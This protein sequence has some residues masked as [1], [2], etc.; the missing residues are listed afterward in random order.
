MDDDFGF[1]EGTSISVLRQ[2]LESVP[3]LGVIGGAEYD[4]NLTKK[5][6]KRKIGL[7]QGF[8]TRR[9]GTIYKAKVHPSN[10][11]YTS[12]GDYRFAV[13]GHT[14]NFL[15]IRRSVLE[16]VAW[17]E[18]LW[19]AGEHLD[20]SL[21]LAQAGWLIGFTPDCWHEHRDDRIPA[22]VYAKRDVQKNL[23]EQIFCR[24][25]GI[26]SVE[27]FEF[28]SLLGK[29]YPRRLMWYRTVKRIALSRFARMEFLLKRMRLRRRPSGL[30]AL[31]T[32][33]N[34]LSPPKP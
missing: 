24:E 15:L 1:C 4:I 6:R 11:H 2:I 13:V 31:L 7:R 32:P 28:A 21:R 3:S 22:S 30:G 18:D 8:L 5:K 19:M 29:L 27:R 14:T 23:K 12:A 26:G 9:D 34:A 33:R 10:L 25:Y 17:N 20:F 16:K